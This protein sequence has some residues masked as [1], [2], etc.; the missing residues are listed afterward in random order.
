MAVA[1]RL[2][3][4]EALRIPQLRSRIETVG[5]SLSPRPFLFRRLQPLSTRGGVSDRLPTGDE[6][7]AAVDRM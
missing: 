5:D 2:G 3:H 4:D 7:L 1:P 6:V